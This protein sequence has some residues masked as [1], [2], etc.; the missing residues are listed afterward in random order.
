MFSIYIADPEPPKKKPKILPQEPE[1][2]ILKRGRPNFNY[3]TLNDDDFNEDDYIIH[4]PDT[5]LIND[6]AV[7]INDDT[8][9]I[10]DDTVLIKGF[11]LIND[12]TLLINNDTVLINDTPADEKPKSKSRNDWMEP[13]VE[14]MM[15]VGNKS[16]SIMRMMNQVI[17]KYFMSSINFG[18]ILS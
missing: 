12:D 4:S 11:P 7:L 13:I 18:F 6:D 5:V 14:E 3:G 1:T 16:L 9:L 8:V 2:L 15:I 17:G 10:N